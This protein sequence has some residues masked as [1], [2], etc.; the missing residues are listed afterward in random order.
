MGNKVRLMGEVLEV[1]VCETPGS[2]LSS[3]RERVGVTFHGFDGDQH[4]GI[5]MAS[6]S[7]TPFYPHGTEIRN[8]RQVSIVSAEELAEVAALLELSEL[9]PAWL[10]A[11][12]LVSGIP[13]LTLLPGMTRLFFSSPATAGSATSG[14]S[15]GSGAVLLAQGE[16][17]PCSTAGAEVA[18]QSGVPGLAAEFAGAAR[19][20]RGIVAVVERPGEIC[21]G[22]RVVIDLPPVLPYPMQ[23]Q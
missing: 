2:I 5:V 7:R 11:N 23:A 6:G 14:A 12:L 15:R 20:R 1:L 19:H 18:R 13:N 9:P 17:H 10:G 4:S 3:V 22:G 8:S 16:N 21:K